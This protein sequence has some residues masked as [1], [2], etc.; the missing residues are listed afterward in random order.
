MQPGRGLD[1]PA[2]CFV[3]ETRNARRDKR[4]ESK[5]PLRTVL[6]WRTLPVLA[7]VEK[8]PGCEPGFNNRPCN[9][10]AKNHIITIMLF[11]L[12]FRCIF[13]FLSSLVC[14][15][16]NWARAN[17]IFFDAVLIVRNFLGSHP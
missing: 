3:A 10:V 11:A 6:T 8:N 13:A 1:R 5:T 2:G 15:I 4:H 16:F 7:M 12:I 9:E 17:T 14:C